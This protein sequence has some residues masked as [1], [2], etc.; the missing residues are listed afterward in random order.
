M[1]ICPLLVKEIKNIY[2]QSQAIKVKQVEWHRD[3]VIS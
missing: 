1:G 2:T 3:Q